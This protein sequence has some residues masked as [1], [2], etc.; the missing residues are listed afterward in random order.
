MAKDHIPANIY[1]P[2][3]SAV[4]CILL[5]KM[6]YSIRAFEAMAQEGATT[7]MQLCIL[8]GMLDTHVPEMLESYASGLMR[9][10]QFCNRLGMLEEVRMPASRHLLTLFVAETR[11][12][13][14]GKCIWNWLNALHL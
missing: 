13:R 12:T 1:R 6:P 8:E 3:V 11:G 10:N 5:W 14:T 4:H 9:F 7:S 2:H